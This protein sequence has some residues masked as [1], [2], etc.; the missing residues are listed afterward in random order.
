MNLVRMLEWIPVTTRSGQKQ[1]HL[2]WKIVAFVNGVGT[3][4]IQTDSRKGWV[5]LKYFCSFISLTNFH[6]FSMDW[7]VYWNEF[8]K[9]IQMHI[10]S[11]LAWAAFETA[12]RWCSNVHSQNWQSLWED[13]H[14]KCW[15][16]VSAVFLER[17]NID[18]WKQIVTGIGR[19]WY[20]TDVLFKYKFRDPGGF[21][22]DV[23][24]S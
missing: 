20:C 18:L 3:S 17:W 1:M 5:K 2:V 16:Q 14:Y 19:V 22:W 10:L 9:V 7:G 15:R 4:N 6:R 24:Y 21:G 8:M 12:P 11:R 13:K 23:V